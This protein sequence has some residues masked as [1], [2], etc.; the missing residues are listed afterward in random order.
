MRYT[1][2]RHKVLTL[3]LAAVTT[4]TVA[5]C[6]LFVNPNAVERYRVVTCAAT[7]VSG[8]GAL[9]PIH[10]GLDA[11]FPSRRYYVC[12]DDG[13][14]LEEAKP[15][16]PV[17]DR[18]EDF[19]EDWGRYAWRQIG[20][21]ASGELPFPESEFAVLPGPWCLQEETLVC[22]VSGELVPRRQIPADPDF[23]LDPLPAEPDEEI[24]CVE[25]PPPVDPPPVEPCLEITCAGCQP[26]VEGGVETIHLAR[27]FG[28]V[29]VG[30]ASDPLTV[31]IANCTADPDSEPIAVSA[32]GTVFSE[33]PPADFFVSGNTCIPDPATEPQGKLL[34]PVGAGGTSSCTFNMTFAP[35]VPFA[36]GGHVRIDSD[37]S[38]RLELTGTGLGGALTVTA[39]D[40]GAAV[41]ELCFEVA[42][43]S[44]C[45]SPVDLLIGNAGPGRLEVQTVALED[46][47]VGYTLDS[48]LLGQLPWTLEPGSLPVALEVEGCMAEAGP[49]TTVL[50]IGS[51][52]PGM[53]GYTI[54]LSVSDACP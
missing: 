52:Q 3:M 42:G 39:A 30:G 51:D 36:H 8:D 21:L 38:R 34:A 26:V 31:K 45:G 19:E 25:P 1:T 14:C 7:A 33:V 9:V 10:T 22:R 13:N 43:G 48:V 40:S 44:P 49:E 11:G 50:A 2:T 53:P 16:I 29:A 5:G 18:V 15:E 27:D 6:S 46:D 12:H 41:T 35:E 17:G 32:D 37:E 20:R 4:A 28:S 54:D 47:D 23:V 24:F